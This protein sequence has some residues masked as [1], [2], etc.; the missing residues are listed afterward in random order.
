MIF[1]G[2]RVSFKVSNSLA[3]KPVDAVAE[4]AP[5]S[6]SDCLN[7]DLK[8]RVEPDLSSNFCHTNITSKHILLRKTLVLVIECNL[9]ILYIITKRCIIIIT[10][11][12][13]FLG[14]R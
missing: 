8:L 4:R 5:V 1:S 12:Y 3:E 14:K 6:V 13:D 10:N 2:R 11:N 7:L 9:F